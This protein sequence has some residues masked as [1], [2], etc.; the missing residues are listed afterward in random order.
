MESNVDS[1]AMPALLTCKSPIDPNN[2]GGKK[3]WMTGEAMYG[4][5]KGGVLVPNL[6]LS[7]PGRLLD[8]R[9]GL[10]E[11]LATSKKVGFE[12]ACGANG[13]VWLRA[14]DAPAT[15]A[16]AGCVEGAHG[17][18]PEDRAGMAREAAKWINRGEGA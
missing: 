3:D 2:V 12:V 9:F 8:G 4:P 11:A 5:L 1:G 10:L 6:P 15:A 7:Y 17:L 13:A 16:I 14:G 18:R